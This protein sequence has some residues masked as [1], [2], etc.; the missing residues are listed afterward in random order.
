MNTL[1]KLEK[2]R[3]LKLELKLYLKFVRDVLLA[4][5]T[6]NKHVLWRII[7]LPCRPALF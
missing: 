7:I 4:L 3:T 2:Q 1:Y 5:E 6:H